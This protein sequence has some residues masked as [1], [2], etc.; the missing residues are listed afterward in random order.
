[1]RIKKQ[2]DR[3]TNGQTGRHIDRQTDIQIGGQTDRHTDRQADRQMGGQTDG[4][5]NKQQF[6]KNII[7]KNSIGNRKSGNPSFFKNYS[8]FRLSTLQSEV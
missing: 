2:V 6:Y 1:M 3:Q 5:P 7:L 4:K 8:V